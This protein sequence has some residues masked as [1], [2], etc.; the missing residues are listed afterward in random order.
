MH[1]CGA[2]CLSA[3]LPVCMFV[4]LNTSMLVCRCVC[5]SSLMVSLIHEGIHAGWVVGVRVCRT[6]DKLICICVYVCKWLYMLTWKGTRAL[7]DTHMQISMH[8][9]CMVCAWCVHRHRHGVHGTPPPRH[10]T[11]IQCTQL[12]HDSIINH[13]FL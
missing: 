5:P 6:I 10:H 4:R 9:V 1:V 3:C 13:C 12:K 11:H 8:G 7:A 2:A